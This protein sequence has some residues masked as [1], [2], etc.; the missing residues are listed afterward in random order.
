MKQIIEVGQLD[1]ETNKIGIGEISYNILPTAKGKYNI[2]YDKNRTFLMAIPVGVK[3][4]QVVDNFKKTKH[5]V[6]SDFAS[7]SFLDPSRIP[8]IGPVAIPNVKQYTLPDDIAEDI[9][10]RIALF[11]GIHKGR[12]G[13][14]KQ[15]EFK[16]KT[17]NNAYKSIRYVNDG[18]TKIFMDNKLWMIYASTGGDGA[19][20]IYKAKTP[21]DGAFAFLIKS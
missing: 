15:C 8:R 12:T 17:S 14:K 19:F 4:S 5:F 6:S 10:T 13:K 9:P 20:P 3:I 21:V 2:Y 16:L 18:Y 1:L 7:M 11:D